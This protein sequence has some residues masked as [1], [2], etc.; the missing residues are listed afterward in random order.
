MLHGGVACVVLMLL[1]VAGVVVVVLVVPTAITM[2]V[3]FVGRRNSV[4]NYK[5]KCVLEKKSWKLSFRT[6][7]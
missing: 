1:I 6:V 5:K 3:A 4:Y 7:L 2:V